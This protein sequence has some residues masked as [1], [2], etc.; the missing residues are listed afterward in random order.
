MT[1]DTVIHKEAIA[2]WGWVDNSPA[3]P[4]DSKLTMES[5]IHPGEFTPSDIRRAFTKLNDILGRRYGITKDIVASGDHTQGLQQLYMGVSVIG[6][7]NTDDSITLPAAV[8]NGYCK[9]INTT[10]SDIQAFPDTD[11]KI[12]GGSAN[13]AITIPAGEICV[14]EAVDDENWYTYKG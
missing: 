12:D 11:D 2:K 3:P 9:V 13:A 6:S 5:T 1:G 8:A 7:A 10:S 14:F 4:A